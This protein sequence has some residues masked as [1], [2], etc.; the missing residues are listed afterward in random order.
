MLQVA[1]QEAPSLTLPRKRGRGH[2]LPVSVSEQAL[3]FP[4]GKLLSFA[5]VMQNLTT[6]LGAPPPPLAGEGRGGGTPHPEAFMDDADKQAW[7][8]NAKTRTR[9]KAL[10]RALTDC[11]RRLWAMLRAHRLN[12]ASFR[13]QTPVGPYIADFVCHA[14]K[15]I[16]E[17]DGGQHFNDAAELRDAR[18]DAFLASKG[19]RV[20]RFSNHDVLTNRQG[21]LEAIASALEEAPSLS[22]PRKGGG[23]AQTSAS[24]VARPSSAR[25]RGV[26][27]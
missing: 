20:V 10:R 24:H 8:V 27:P 22:L 15:L 1:Q 14:A 16:I 23:N 6:H 13:R 25:S 4:L 11:E 26:R 2:L 7:R 17:L 3:P 18:R 5:V 9:A 12:G 21:V 19:F